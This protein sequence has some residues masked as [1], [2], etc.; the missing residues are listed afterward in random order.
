MSRHLLR[1]IESLNSELLGISSV[2]EEMIDNATQAL[3]ERRYDLVERVIAS[4]QYVDEHEVHVEEECLKILALH[5]PVA[6]DLRRIA[7]LMKVNND[8]E[9]IADLAVS[10]SE[11]ARAIE[12]FPEFVI[13]DDLRR[14]VNLATQIVRGAMDA[15]VNLDTG[16]ARRIISLDVEVD[17]YNRSIIDGLCTT[18]QQHS[19]LV[20]PALNC[21]SAVRHTERIADHATNIAED[22]IYLVEGDIIRHRNTNTTAA[23]ST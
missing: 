17:E 9:R 5:Q 4:D 11:R 15:L 2:V 10:M 20:Q 13:P 8:L 22:V 21:F 1:D 14:M 3:T 6:V 16:A 19:H 12:P 18:M 7:T 23:G